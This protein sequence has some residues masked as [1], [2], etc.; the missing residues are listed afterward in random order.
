[1]KRKILSAIAACFVYTASQAQ[2]VNDTVVTLPSYA[3]NVWYS[4]ANDD[5]ATS[6]ANT[7]HMGLIAGTSTL[8]VR[9]FD[10][11]NWAVLFNTDGTAKNEQPTNLIDG[12]MHETADAVKQW[13]D[14]NLFEK[15]K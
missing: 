11:L 15:F 12:P 14:T 7:W 1:M 8:L 9:R 4:L 10:G 5:Q 2:V 6:A 3:N 13:P